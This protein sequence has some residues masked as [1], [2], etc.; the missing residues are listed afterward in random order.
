VGGTAVVSKQSFIEAA[1]GLEKMAQEI[2]GPDYQSHLKS[3]V[4]ASD[5]SA[6]LNRTS[7]GRNLPDGDVRGR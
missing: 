4:T 3:F 5:K 6:Y 1:E 2:W 7:Q